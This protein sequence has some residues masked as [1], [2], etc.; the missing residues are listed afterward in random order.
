MSAIP[1]SIRASYLDDT[2]HSGPSSPG[3]SHKP[4]QFCVSSLLTTG[5]W[6]A[7]T[8][9]HLTVSRGVLADVTW[10]TSGCDPDWVSEARVR[11]QA[12]RSGPVHP[13][14]IVVSSLFDQVMR[15]F[16]WRLGAI[17]P[18]FGMSSER[19]GVQVDISSGGTSQTDTSTRD[20]NSIQNAAHCC[21]L[22]TE[23]RVFLLFT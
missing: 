14:W 2:H 19:V 16:M 17:A 13:A 18:E 4:L 22:A 5:A 8:W 1:A 6:L 20:L 11:R 9:L 3:N 21:Y 7:G 15:G 10:K 12:A 23:S